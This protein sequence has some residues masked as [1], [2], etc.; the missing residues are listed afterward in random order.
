MPDPHASAGATSRLVDRRFDV[1]YVGPI[2]G[3]YTLS[4]RREL[5][6][7]GVEVYACRT[8]SI[9]AAAAAITAPVTGV[10]GEW[11]TARFDHIGIVRGQIERLTPDG[12]V[13]QINISDEERQKLALKITWLKR[14]SVRLQEDKREFRRFQPRDPRSTLTLADGAV[15]KC[16]VIDLSRNGAALSA[17]QRPAVGVPVVIGKLKSHVVRHLEIGFAVA[18][19][20]AQD[21]EGLEQLVTGIGLNATV[22]AGIWS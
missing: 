8:Q 14:K 7:A 1:R 17:H 21:A 13:F 9:S 11:V 6:N 3:C 19:E 22:P 18:F 2:S 4:D 12:F 5:G 15:I 16:F 20:A 10:A